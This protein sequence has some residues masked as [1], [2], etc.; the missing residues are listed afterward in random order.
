MI[1]HRDRMDLVVV[2]SSGGY[3]C[4]FGCAELVMGRR[5][6]QDR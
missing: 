6:D 1:G 3:A 2:P 5:E 4:L